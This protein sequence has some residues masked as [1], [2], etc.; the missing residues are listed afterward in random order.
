MEL[1]VDC[2]FRD[3]VRCTH[4]DLKA[5]GG[6][7]S[8]WT[9]IRAHRC[10][11]TLAAAAGR[12]SP[13]IGNRSAPVSAG[14]S[15]CSQYPRPCNYQCDSYQARLRRVCEKSVGPTGSA[16]VSPVP[17]V[18]G[19]GPALPA[20]PAR[21]RP[22]GAHPGAHTG[23]DETSAVPE[24]PGQARRPRSQDFS[25]TL[26]DYATHDVLRVAM[27]YTVRGGFTLCLKGAAP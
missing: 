12:S 27:R 1:C 17:S 7:V 18:R 4:R 10:M 23:A 14:V 22:S 25:Q 9:P 19:R 2:R 24:P 8:W 26:H 13:S 11:S 16:G 20:G 21:R 6:Q 3:G 5:N 15:P